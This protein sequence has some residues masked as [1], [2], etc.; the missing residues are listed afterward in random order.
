MLKS[1]LY[2]LDFLKTFLLVL[3]LSKQKK[4][5]KNFKNIFIVFSAGAGDFVMFL[6]TFI[7]IKKRFK[8][9]NVKLIIDRAVSYSIA[10]IFHQKEDIILFDDKN[11]LTD[12]DLLIFAYGYNKINYSILKSNKN[13]CFIGFACD[14]KIRSNCV[15]TDLTDHSYDNHI[16]SNFKIANLL[17]GDDIKLK[18]PS[19]PKKKSIVDSNNYIVVNPK[20]KGFSRN[21]PVEF[22]VDLIK[23]IINVKNIKI[24]L[25]GG[26]EDVL[27]SNIIEKSVNNNLL[28][29]LTGKITLEETFY[30]VNS[31]KIL[32]TGDSGI[33]HFG[34]LTNCYT[35]ALFGPTNPSNYLINNNNKKIISLNK[36]FCKYGVISKKCN[37]NKIESCNFIKMIKPKEVF[38]NLKNKL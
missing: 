13:A 8:A 26:P 32:I 38:D 37:C 4:S 2:R 19:Y 1:F 21:W 33:M 35:I 29:N 18:Y 6:P 10:N 11:N 24:I 36:N 3:F 30:V 20:S 28:L 31:S 23:K 34:F 27:S 15:K 7:E 25:V 16:F 12:A 17:F 5:I 9:A 22:Y 14:N